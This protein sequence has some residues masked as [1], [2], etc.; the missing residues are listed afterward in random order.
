M[1]LDWYSE[2]PKN[3]LY[4]WQKYMSNLHLLNN[5]KI[6]RYIMGSGEIRRLEIHGFSDASIVAYGARL[7]LRTINECQECTVQLIYAKS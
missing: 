6:P 4:E 1:K 2:L 7:Y 5:L 3:L